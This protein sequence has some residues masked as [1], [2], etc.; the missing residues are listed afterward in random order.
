[1]IWN[2]NEIPDGRNGRS[3][4]WWPGLNGA[5][6]A[7]Y[8]LPPSAFC[9][10]LSAFCLL[11][12]GCAGYHIGNATLFPPDISTVYVPMVDSHSFRPDLGEALT[13]A[14]CKQIEKETPYKVVGS[15]NADSILTAKI[16]NDTKRVIVRN[17]F[18]EP[19]STEVNY[20]VQVTWI[21]RKG[22]QI[23]NGAVPLPPEFTTLGQSSAYIPAYG[24]SYTTSEYYVVQ[25]MAQQIV[26]LMERPW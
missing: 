16:V 24:Q 1:M 26:G 3:P 22:D 13:E 5:S 14:I 2:A 6:P 12:S 18:D 8:R 19:Q 21:N 11:S 7:A 9:L 15:P 17:K 4:A 10:L 23:Y 25:K 20:Q